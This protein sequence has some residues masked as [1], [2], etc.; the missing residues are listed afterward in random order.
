[1]KFD[2]FVTSLNVSAGI[3]AAVTA[4]LTIRI[5]GALTWTG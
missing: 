5:K 1:M 3:D 2:G 4:D